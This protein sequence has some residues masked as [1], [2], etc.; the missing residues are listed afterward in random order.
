MERR[1]KKK[2][3]HGLLSMDY[4]HILKKLDQLNF[5]FSTFHHIA[6]FRKVI[7]QRCQFEWAEE[8]F[9]WRYDLSHLSISMLINKDFMVRCIF[10]FKYFKQNKESGHCW[11]SHLQLCKGSRWAYFRLGAC[12]ACKLFWWNKELAAGIMVGEIDQMWHNWTDSKDVVVTAWEI[13]VFRQ[14][15]H[16]RNWNSIA[17][18]ETLVTI[19]M[20]VLFLWY[21]LLL[22]E[23]CQQVS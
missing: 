4:C 16:G 19:Q 1:E 15:M 17:S 2:K 9:L 6:S 14:M 20:D 21:P 18:K 11:R 7:V 22:S 8:L 10:C 12:N 13:C 3:N 23:F 5:C